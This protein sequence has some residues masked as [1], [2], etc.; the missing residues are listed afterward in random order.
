MKTN[1]LFARIFGIFCVVF[2]LGVCA[3][4]AH[5]LRPYPN[6]DVNPDT[7][8]KRIEKGFILT[9]DK[10]N[11]RYWA[12]PPQGKKNKH[13]TLVFAHS[14][15]G[16]ISWNINTAMALAKDGYNVLMFDYRGFGQ[17]T[18]FKIQPNLLYYNEFATDLVAAVGFAKTHFQGN[19]TGIW[20]FGMGTI[21]TTLSYKETKPDFIVGDSY[22]LSPEDM[23]KNLSDAKTRYFVPTATKNYTKEVYGLNVPTL[24]ING[25]KDN[26]TPLNPVLSLRKK[27]KNVMV[28][29][30]VGGF[31]EAFGIM[32][33]VTA[34]SE[35][36]NTINTFL[37]HYKIIN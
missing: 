16:N 10:Y 26:I 35:Y 23:A 32:S 11:L 33:G 12:I 25:D 2:I 29:R 17:S 1:K 21:L 30:H 15:E 24:M 37:K 9:S 14:D 34:G 18:T 3:H 6:Y 31:Q 28:Y 20:A 27:N 7:M 36:V 19:K 22:C 13:I 5:A 4:K 8:R